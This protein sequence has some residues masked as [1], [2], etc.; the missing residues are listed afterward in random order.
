M[1]ENGTYAVM[2]EVHS[3][4][5]WKH[6][7]AISWKITDEVVTQYQCLHRWNGRLKNHIAV[8]N[9]YIQS[10]IMWKSIVLL[11]CMHTLVKMLYLSRTQRK[12]LCRENQSFCKMI[13]FSGGSVSSVC[14]ADMC[15]LFCIH[16]PHRLT[17][18]SCQRYNTR[19]RVWKSVKIQWE[20]NG[21]VVHK[22]RP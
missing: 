8:V 22:N 20:Y 9:F 21:V 5:I 4:D 17:Y 16:F 12:K 3:L 1:E 6:F 19:R 7:N 11:C 13:K 2:T 15:L 10:K 14:L 18:Q